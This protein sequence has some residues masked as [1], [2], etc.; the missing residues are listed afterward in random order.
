[1]KGSWRER[2]DA[3]AE[4]SEQEERDA[5]MKAAA[6]TEEEEKELLRMQNK[7]EVVRLWVQ[8]K[9]VRV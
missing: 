8:G 4:Q 9:T 7:E 3:L 6:Q 1:M 2:A 5:I